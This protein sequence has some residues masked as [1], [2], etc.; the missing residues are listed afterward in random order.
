MSLAAGEEIPR[1]LNIGGGVVSSVR[2]AVPRFNKFLVENIFMND[3]L[4]SLLVD[5]VDQ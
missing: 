2:T 5:L 1:S 3:L 4:N